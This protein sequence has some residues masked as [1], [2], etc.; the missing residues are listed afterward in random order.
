[1]AFFE[2]IGKKITQTGQG[3]VQKTKNMTEIVKLNGQISDEEK[4]IN[5]FIAQIG[6]AYFEKYADQLAPEMLPFINGIKESKS[7]I[8]DYS[9][10]IKQIKG[11]VKC[12]KCGGDVEINAQF[13]ASCG[14]NMNL[15]SSENAPAEAGGTACTGCGKTI[16]AGKSFCTGCGQKI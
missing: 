5:Q 6:N 10:Q 7:K 16:D 1:M 8:N 13:C 14:Q 2:E 4:K 12:A 15:V 3:A 9:E 11:I